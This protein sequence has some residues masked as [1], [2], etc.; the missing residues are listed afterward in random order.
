M[1]Q[2]PERDGLP[3]GDPRWG[4]PWLKGLRRPPQDA[5]WPRLMTVPHP[6][7]AGSLGAEFVAWSKERTGRDLR[8]W[9]RLA[10]ARMLEVDSDGRL[11]WETILLTVPRQL[12]KSW[13]LREL[14]LWRLN[15]SDR[16]GE[17]QDVLHTGKDLRICMEVQRPARI[18]ARTLGGKYRVSESNGKEV[19]ELV[20]A[21]SRWL[22]AA[23]ESVYGYS[24]S[25]AGVDEAWKVR[26]QVVEEGLE[27]TMVEREQAQLLLVSTAHRL[28]TSLMLGRRGAALDALET[29][30]GSLL[31]EWSAPPGSDLEDVA[32]WRQ[33]SSHWS[34][35]RE[36]T[37]RQ[38]LEAA[39][40]G[41]LRDP[42]EPDPVA[43]FRS[44]WLN[45]WPATPASMLGNAEPLLPAGLWA[46]RA[47]EG[48]VSSGPIWVALEDNYGKDAAVAAVGML[49]DG[50]LE[51]DGWRCDDWDSAVESVEQLAEF[52]PVRQLLVGA[53]LID[54][55][56]SGMTPP[57]L[58]AGGAQTRVGLAVFRDL[59]AG[60]QIVHDVNTRDVDEAVAATDVREAP[61]G[62]LI[63]RGPRYLIHAVVWAVAAA[64]K[65]APVLAVR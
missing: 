44:Q 30:D 47:V 33:A 28:A 57:P 39:Q 43:S 65:P 5:A 25:L 1:E 63:V 37:I 49:D 26:P 22:I 52:R 27:P 3:A 11:V 4:V 42:D 15:Q 53:S 54:R 62:L 46:D 56:P 29:G 18:W 60:G 45:Q 20:E 32:A 6:R 59:A 51:V 40:S 13:L 61:S 9:Q 21:G 31:L 16:F 12:G 19:I 35:R 10:A 58:P 64:H 7:A 24:V 34:P 17:P 41:T 38:H 48:L 2:E 50:R 36:R 14:I 23:Q 8:W 55:F